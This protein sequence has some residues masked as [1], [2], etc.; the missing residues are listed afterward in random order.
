[1][2]VTLSPNTK[3]LF[4]LFSIRA[5]DPPGQRKER[6]A[7]N[8]KSKIDREVRKHRKSMIRLQRSNSTMLRM[9]YILLHN[10]YVSTV[11]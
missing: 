5:E 10:C 1:M 8:G 7:N 4:K 3:L 2:F 11:L 6:N 9:T